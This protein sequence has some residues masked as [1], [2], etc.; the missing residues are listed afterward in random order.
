MSPRVPQRILM[1]GG[2]G[3]V[4]THLRVAL[5]ERWPHAEA[6]DLASDAMGEARVDLLDRDAVEAAVARARPDVVIHLAAQA[7][8]N[9]S[10]RDQGET[11]AVNLGGTL[12]LA[13]AIAD[14][15]PDALVLFASSSEVYGASFL[16]GAV[17][18]TS[19]LLPMN[20]YARSKAR[21]EA[22]LGDVLGA[23]TPLIVARPFNHTGPG[24]REDYVLPSF[25]GQVARI[26]AG[27]QEP[28]LA[29]GNIDVSRDF[30][31]VRDVADAY[32]A[33]IAVSTRLPARFVCNIASEA[34]RPLREHI[35]TLRGLAR[36]PF[37]IVVDP[38][39]QRPVDLPVASG[40]SRLL[41]AV[42]DWR[43]AWDMQATIGEMLAVS[44]EVWLS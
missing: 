34:S 36:R 27:I 18:E 9:R 20:A 31:D 12:N 35:E 39:R 19:P 10:S 17:D 25:I 26:E 24:Q 33:L 32:V 15:A 37:E 1:T 4:G 30:L 41:R 2:A 3:F 28:R 8:A 13:L 21:A 44:R 7:S 22:V 29:V 6:L 23:R 42:T 14:K 5:A 16:R 40:S 38:A 11:W 43:P